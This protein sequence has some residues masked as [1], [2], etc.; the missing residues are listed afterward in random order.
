MYNDIDIELARDLS[1][2]VCDAVH[3]TNFNDN[4]DQWPLLVDKLMLCEITRDVETLT[5]MEVIS[6]VISDRSG[7]GLYEY[8]QS[9]SCR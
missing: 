2:I 9:R 3:D 5:V 8:T 6:V 7:A 4:H 1:V